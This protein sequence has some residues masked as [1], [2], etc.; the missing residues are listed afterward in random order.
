MHSVQTYSLYQNG[1]KQY[2]YTYALQF[3]SARIHRV[4]RKPF[5]IRLKT[6]CAE[7]HASNT[8]SDVCINNLPLTFDDL[9]KAIAQYINLDKRMTSARCLFFLSFFF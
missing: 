4:A 1:M 8:F 5:F 6:I 2:T 7:M 3:T 9:K